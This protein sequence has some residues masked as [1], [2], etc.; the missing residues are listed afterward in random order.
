MTGLIGMLVI[1]LLALFAPVLAPQ[2]P[3]D[4]AQLS[5]VDG[6]LPPGTIGEMGLYYWLGTDEQGRDIFSAIL[7]GL[8]TSLMVGVLSVA[9]ALII[10]SIY[11]LIAA[12]LGGRADT[13]MMRIVDLQL[14][15]PTILIALVLLAAL[16]KGIDKIIIALV[17]AQWAMFA[18]TARSSALVEIKKEYIQAA[19]CLRLPHSHILFLHLLPNC[20]SP[21][22]VLGTIT[23]ASAISLEATLSFLGLGVPITNP[24]LGMLISNGFEYMLS[25]RYWISTYPGLALL[26]TIM[27][28]NITGDHMRDMLNPRLQH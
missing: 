23:I 3:Y 2:N 19:R 17:T 14:S 26:F 25:D 12:Y 5:I 6:R 9:L 8:R 15:I 18:R 27:C 1:I 22:I 24:S 13:L 21:L 20:L 10:G 7:Y 28:I 11:G 16:G 4:L